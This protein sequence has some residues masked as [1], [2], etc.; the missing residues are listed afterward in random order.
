MAKAAQWYR[1]LEIGYNIG[2]DFACIQYMECIRPQPNI[3]EKFG[4]LQ[5]RRG[6]GDEMSPIKEFK[7]FSKKTKNL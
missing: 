6:T 1:W 3:Y 4:L 7:A 2:E 5:L